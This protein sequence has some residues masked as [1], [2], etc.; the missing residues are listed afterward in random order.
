MII[1]GWILLRMINVSDKNCKDNH[2]AHFIFNDAFPKI[3]PFVKQCGK[4][5]GRVRQETDSNVIECMSFACCIIKATYT[6]SE[7]VVKSSW[8][9]MT[10]SDAQEGK[11]RGKWRMEWVDSTFHTTLE[12]SVSS[13]TTADAYSSAAS[14]RLNWRPCRF[15]WNRPFRRKT[16][17]GFCTCAIAFQTRSTHYLSTATVVTRKRYNATLYLF[18]M[19]CCCSLGSRLYFVSGMN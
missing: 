19:F 15:K 6:H 9:M 3:V 2:N 18:C 17:S 4:K 13:I 11:W 8:N 7:H 16:K 14:S 5:N 1:S 10:H 12:H